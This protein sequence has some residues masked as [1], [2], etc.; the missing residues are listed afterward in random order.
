MFQPSPFAL[1]GHFLCLPSYLEK[2]LASAWTVAFWWFRCGASCRG[3]IDHK[4]LTTH[5][6]AIRTLLPF[7][8]PWRSVKTKFLSY[9]PQHIEMLMMHLAQNHCHNTCCFHGLPLCAGSAADCATVW[10][11][12]W[13]SR[14]MST[15]QA[16]RVFRI[17]C[18][19]IHA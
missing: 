17:C 8:S 13:S 11:F 12:A 5:G 15:L 10:E 14:V 19:S 9:L 1:A 3:Q 16:Q 6:P 2:F 4:H 7:A 18:K